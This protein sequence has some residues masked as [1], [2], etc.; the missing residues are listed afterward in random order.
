MNLW[1]IA[2]GAWMRMAGLWVM[3]LVCGSLVAQV[4]APAQWWNALTRDDAADV[5]GMLLRH[6]DPNSVDEKTG[7]PSIMFAVRNESWKVYDLLRRT[8]GIQLD[9][10]NRLGETALMYLSLTG[11]T[12]RA[13]ALIDAGAQVNRLGWTPLHYAASKGRN[14]TLQMLIA[15]HAIVNAPGPDGTTPLMMAALSGRESTVRLLLENGAD[16]TMFNLKHQTAADWA[17]VGEHTGLADKLSALADTVAARRVMG[18]QNETAPASSAAPAS[19]PAV[20]PADEQSISRYFA[21]GKIEHV[22]AGQ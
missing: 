11:E 14:E 15:H 12:Q 18:P 1:K 13:Q 20:S 17:R 3:L 4:A 6:V 19:A 8:P 9:A 22:P 16:A 2:P 7:L 21:P 5:S 10:P